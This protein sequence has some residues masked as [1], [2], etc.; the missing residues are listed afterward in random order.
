MAANPALV[1]VQ[2][3]MTPAPFQGETLALRREGVEFLV[4]GLRTES[5]KWQAKGALWLSDV[6]MVFVAAGPV[7]RDGL[8]AFDIPLAYVSHDKFN[9]PVFGCN[10][11]S[12]KVWPAAE[13]GGPAGTLPPHD[14][15]IWFTNG[16][17]GT[18]LPLY[19]RFIRAAAVALQ[20]AS[21]G[22]P[23]SPTTASAP[24]APQM[25]SSLVATAI[26]D[27]SDPS[28]IF[29]TQPVDESRRLPST[30]VYASNYGT[31]EKYEP[32]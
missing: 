31:D 8:Q 9:Q 21:R 22:Q 2:G 18:L 24:S 30:P 15:K 20:Q 14:Y 32:M 16:G 6:R 26:V 12:G 19:Y 10:H 17:V 1:N 3:V 25:P 23:A 29:L 28:K 13:G 5:G 27:P 7:G 11:L 4:D